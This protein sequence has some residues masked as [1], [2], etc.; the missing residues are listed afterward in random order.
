MTVYAPG[1][2]NLSV[3]DVSPPGLSEDGGLIGKLVL[4]RAF[5]RPGAKL[6]VTGYVQRRVNADLRLLEAG[7][8]TDVWVRVSPHPDPD[9]SADELLVPA[10]LDYRYGS[11]QPLTIMLPENAELINYDVQLVVKLVSESWK[12]TLD[13]TSFAAADPRLPTATVNMTAPKWVSG[14]QGE[15]VVVRRCVCVCVR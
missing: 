12:N 6:Y 8:V 13:Y 3:T 10:S 14:R 2:G 1:H 11:L 9:T 15:V 4:D 7:D 5:V